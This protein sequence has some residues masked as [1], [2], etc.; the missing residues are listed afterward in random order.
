MEPVHLD[1]SDVY[2]ERRFHGSHRARPVCGR[3]EVQEALPYSRRLLKSRFDYHNHSLKLV[4]IF[5]LEKNGKLEITEFRGRLPRHLGWIH[6]I[7]VT[8]CASLVSG[9]LQSL[10]LT[11]L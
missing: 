3:R 11:V 6:I 8:F 4:F 2:I 10:R 5:N 9:I 7:P 1:A